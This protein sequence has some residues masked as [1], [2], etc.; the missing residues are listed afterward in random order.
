MNEQAKKRAED[1]RRFRAYQVTVAAW[2]TKRLSFWKREKIGDTKEYKDALAEY[3][4]F[5]QSDDI[6]YDAVVTYARDL[7]ASYEKTDRSHDDK[8]DAIIRYLG[9]GSAIVTF[10]TLISIKSD[11]IES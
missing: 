6:D 9:G 5:K 1:I 7:Y 11:A 8:A 3:Q 4:K 10:G 2:L